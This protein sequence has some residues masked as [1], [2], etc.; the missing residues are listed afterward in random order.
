M[1]YR[2]PQPQCGQKQHRVCFALSKCTFTALK[3]SKYRNKTISGQF[4]PAYNQIYIPEM[5]SFKKGAQK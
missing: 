3:E 2:P 4:F 5:P 1:V